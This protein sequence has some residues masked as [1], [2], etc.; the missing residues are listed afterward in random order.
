MPSV[1]IEI[2]TPIAVP[3]ELSRALVESCTNAVHEGDCVLDGDSSEPSPTAVVIVRWD[4]DERHARI[5]LGTKNHGEAH[6]RNRDLRF[7]DA[8]VRIERWRTVGLTIATLA[9][10]AARA[11]ANHAEVR[12]APPA[13]TTGPTSGAEKPAR[14]EPLPEPAPSALWADLG[15]LAGTGLDVGGPRLG[16]WA[17]VGSRIAQSPVMGVVGA[18]YSAVDGTGSLS[19]QWLVFSAGLGAEIGNAGKGF[20]FEPSVRFAVDILHAS[21]SEG[22]R[23]DSGALVGY[24]GRA[25]ATFV[26]QLGLVSPVFGAEGW[27]DA[28]PVR[29]LVRDQYVGTVRRAGGAAFLGVRLRI[30]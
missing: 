9:G 22:A 8:D 17:D 2:A 30:R 10:E 5:E 20:L 23:S 4:T 24:G 16:V 15:G 13:S 11:E 6:W 18:S 12:A 28:E 25:D 19:V 27:L 1:A 29:I 14:P 3:A 21:A 7:S 26:W